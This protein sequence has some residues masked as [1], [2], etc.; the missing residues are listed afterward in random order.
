MIQ[1]EA[2]VIVVF[3][4]RFH[5]FLIFRNGPEKADKIREV[6][7]FIGLVDDPVASVIISDLSVPA[8][9]LSVRL[10]IDSPHVI[11]PPF[12]WF[13]EGHKKSPRGL[14]QGLN[15]KKAQRVKPLGLPAFSCFFLQNY[16]PGWI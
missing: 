6:C 15:S 3:K 12:H 9:I 14:S 16:E 13:K 2:H 10:P 8:K 1:H 7:V 4:D 5:A 11:S